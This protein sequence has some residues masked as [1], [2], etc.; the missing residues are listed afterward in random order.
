[1]GTER[2]EEL[3][4][5]ERECLRLVRR[6]QSSKQI[7]LALGISPHTVDARLKKAITLL[8]VSSRYEAAQ[9]LAEHEGRED[10][11]YQPLVYQPS[12]LVSDPISHD[13]KPHDLNEDRRRF[14]VPFLRQGRRI[15]DLEPLQRLVWIGALALLI[16][17]TFANFANALDVMR[18]IA[19]SI[20]R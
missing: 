15:N 3:T 6:D 16:L 20:S 4:Q 8:G 2:I 10:T 1:M 19:S 5:R 11:Y 17:I 18:S 14:R 9:L 12:A 13:P 7:T